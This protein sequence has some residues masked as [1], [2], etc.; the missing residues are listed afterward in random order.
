MVQEK[1]EK[2]LEENPKTW[3]SLTEISKLLGVHISN[4]S[5]ALK[6]MA[7]YKEV[8]A[9]YKEVLKRVKYKQGYSDVI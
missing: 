7:K 1:I 4:V 6:Q 3:H 2:L 9:E 8:E 5:K